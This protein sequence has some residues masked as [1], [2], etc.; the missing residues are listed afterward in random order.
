MSQETHAPA[1]RKRSL[2][3][4]ALVAIVLVAAG[5]GVAYFFMHRAPAAPPPAEPGLVALEPF[6]VNLADAG[7]RRFLRVTLRLVVASKEQAAELDED[8]VRKARARS[9]ILE[10]LSAQHGEALITPDGKAA[11]KK[12]ISEQVSH[13]VEHAQVTDVLFTEFVVQF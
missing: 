4:I 13:A 3:V 11:L 2:G 7:A 9:S 10:L 12:S 6:V 8:A 5:G 1:P